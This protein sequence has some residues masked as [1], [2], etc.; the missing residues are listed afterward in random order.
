MRR[1]QRLAKIVGLA[2]LVAAVLEEYSKPP[3]ERVGCGRAMGIVPYDF[4]FPTLDRLFQA[5]W[6]PEDP[7]LFTDTPL[8]VGWAVNLYRLRQLIWR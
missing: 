3:G 8:G 5:F 2:L 4:R 7:R 1:L 6:N